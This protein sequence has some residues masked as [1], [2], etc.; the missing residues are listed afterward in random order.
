MTHRRLAL[1]DLDELRLLQKV[2]T[3]TR[4][5]IQATI[6]DEEYAKEILVDALIDLDAERAGAGSSTD[7]A[8]ADPDPVPTTDVIN[9]LPERLR[10][11][12]RD[13][14]TRAD[15]A[16]D[17]QRLAVAEDRIRELEALVD[18]LQE[19]D[20]KLITALNQGFAELPTGPYRG[21][22][23]EV[24]AA[25]ERVTYRKLCRIDNYG[26]G[27]SPEYRARRARALADVLNAARRLTQVRRG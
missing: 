14:E 24:R 3:A 22:G 21:I 18:A 4:R 23:D 7:A 20:A 12:V 13:L 27:V 16:G 26:G 19:W 9:A 5:V 25:D 2:E 1:V 15:P 11:F 17:T 6:D 10:A 8:L